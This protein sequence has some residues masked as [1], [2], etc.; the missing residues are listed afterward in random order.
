MSQT[1]EQR[2]W[3]RVNKTDSCWLW[4]GPLEVNGHYGRV[5][6]AGVRWLPHRYAWFVTHG[7]LPRDFDVC[8]NCPGGDNSACVNPAHMFLGTHADNMSDAA[9]K[10]ATD[11]KLSRND[12]AVCRLL[13]ADGWTHKKIAMHFNVKRETVRDICSGKSRKQPW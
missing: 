4:T 6:I 1:I 7:R 13:R 3:S 11:K 9:R 2:F 12:A 10:G 5:S 8:H